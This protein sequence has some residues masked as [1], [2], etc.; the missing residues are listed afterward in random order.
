[1]LRLPFG[2]VLVVC[3]LIV[4]PG[5]AADKADDLAAVLKRLDKLEAENAAL[6]KELAELKQSLTATPKEPPVPLSKEDKAAVET[7]IKALGKEVCEDMIAGRLAGM[8][9]MTSA[10]YRKDKDRKAFDE[11]ITKTGAYKVFVATADN[12]KPV[13]TYTIKAGQKPTK[14]TFY[15]GRTVDYGFNTYRTTVALF[16]IEEDGEW[17]IEDFDLRRDDS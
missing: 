8:Y 6:K 16:F 7:K 12:K 1:M 11:A 14:W 4:S 9:Q 17:K 3:I 10:K 5:R 13:E 2:A 15:Y